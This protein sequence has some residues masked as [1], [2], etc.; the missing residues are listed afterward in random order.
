VDADEWFIYPG[1][2]SQLLPALTAHLERCGAQG[3]FAFLLDMYGSG[4]IAEPT[5]EPRATPFD[6]CRYFDRDYAWRRRFYIPGLQRPWFPQY[7]VIGGPRLRLLFP[8]LHRHYYLLETM[9]MLSYYT[10][11]LTRRTPL[12]VTLRP[13]PVLS[14]IPLVRWLPGTRYQHPHATTP[15]KLADVTGVLLHFKFLPD[16]YVRVANEVKRKEHWDGA[17]EYARYW[18]K[19]KNNPLLSFHYAGS[20]EYEGSE[21]L[22]R[23]GLLREDQAWKQIRGAADGPCIMHQEQAPLFQSR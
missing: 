16:F 4:S 14:K 6:T 9:W 10:Y 15:I 18:E 23:L 20:V 1:Y 12:P 2:E 13:P 8:F 22:I 21:Q 11:L 5:S 7:D 19:L 17:R 3:M